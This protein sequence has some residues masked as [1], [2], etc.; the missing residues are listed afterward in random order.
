M[1]MW[2]E[3]A[4]GIGKGRSLSFSGQLVCN[5][6]TPTCGSYNSLHVVVRQ[7]PGNGFAKPVKLGEVSSRQISVL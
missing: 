3:W 1:K 5:H 7:T 6:L 2:D 4:V